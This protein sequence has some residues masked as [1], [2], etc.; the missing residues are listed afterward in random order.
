RKHGDA[1]AVLRPRHPAGGMLA[2]NKPARAVV[3]Q[4]V[5]LVARLPKGGDIR[6]G[7][8]SPDD[9]AGNVAK[10]EMALD[11]MPDRPLGEEIAG[12]QAL[13]LHRRANPRG[14]AGVAD[15]RRRHFLRDL[16][17]RTDSPPRYHSSAGTSSNTTQTASFGSPDS[18]LTASVTRRAIS[19]F[20]SRGW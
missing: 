11:R 6:V 18:S 10:Q 2:G 19:S 13:E 14:E 3:G 12:P 5:R 1:A 7:A 4:P 9:I 16:T 15:F 17:L 20:L 8:P